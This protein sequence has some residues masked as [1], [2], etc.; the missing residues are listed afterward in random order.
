MFL[1]VTCSFTFQY[2]WCFVHGHGQRTKEIQNKNKELRVS[3]IKSVL[4][5]QQW[6]DQTISPVHT[7]PDIFESATSSFRYGFRPH[8]SSV[9]AS[10]SGYFL[11]RSPE[12][13]KQIRNE[14]DKVWMVNLDIF[15][16]DEQ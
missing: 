9:F 11:I 3:R 13:K 15:E 10:E 1:L 12:W 8:A 5:Y 4:L 6:A 7:Y 14:F 16:S 2:L